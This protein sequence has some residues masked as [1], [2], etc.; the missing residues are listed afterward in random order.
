MYKKND[1]D[2]DIFPCRKEFHLLYALPCLTDNDEILLFIDE[3]KTDSS[4]GQV[5][6]FYNKHVISIAIPS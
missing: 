2:T 5:D 1:K 3:S 4:S 6:K